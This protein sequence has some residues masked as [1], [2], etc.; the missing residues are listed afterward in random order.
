MSNKKSPDKNSRIVRQMQDYH[1]SDPRV[2]Q[3]AVEEIVN[4]H[5]KYVVQ[6]INKHFAAYKRDWWEDLFQSGIMG[7]L[8]SLA[9]YDPEKSRPTTF[10]HFYILHS[11]AEYV[12]EFIQGTTSHYATNLTK[13]NRAISKLEAQGKREPTIADISVV[14]GLKADMVRKALEVKT[15]SQNRS[16]GDEGYMD[17]MASTQ[18]VEQPQE[19]I[20]REEELAVFTKCILELPNAEKQV[21]IR[22]YGLFDTPKQS[23]AQIAEA[24]GVPIEKI[25]CYQAAAIRLLR[26]NPKMKY[27]FHDYFKIHERKEDRYVFETP[28]KQLKQEMDAL[29]DEE[30]LKAIEP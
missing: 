9:N 4:D 24:T 7:L 28:K 21:I 1:S 14:T 30:D 16:C 12:A 6:I 26:K 11:I 2:K 25:R 20:E 27:M 23:N 5:Q 29:C 18:Y 8:E 22:K 15:A 10:F 19:K 3:H 17:S 13:I